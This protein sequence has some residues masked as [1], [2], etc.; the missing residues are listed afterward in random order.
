MFS[1]NIGTQMGLLRGDTPQGSSTGQP[2]IRPGV[3]SR[4]FQNYAAHRAAYMNADQQQPIPQG[5]HLGFLQFLV[6][7]MFLDRLHQHEGDSAN[8][9]KKV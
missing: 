4:E 8:R 5:R 7:A 6:G 2:G 9:L 3:I 1:R